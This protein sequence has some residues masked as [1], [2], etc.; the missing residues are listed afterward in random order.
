MKNYFADLNLYDKTGKH[1]ASDVLTNMIELLH[2]ES[3][4]DEIAAVKDFSQSDLL[5]YTFNKE[6]KKTSKKKFEIEAAE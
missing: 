4:R 3:I 2:D 5:L 6:E 1:N